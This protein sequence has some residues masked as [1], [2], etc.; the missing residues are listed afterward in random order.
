MKSILSVV[1]ALA[2]S[3]LCLTAEQ[4][5]NYPAEEP[6]FSIDFPDDWKVKAEESVSASSPDELVHMELIALEAEAKEEAMDLA[7]ESLAEELKGIKWEG[8]PVSAEA[9]GMDVT[10]LNGKVT[11][12]EVE[13]AVSCVI[14]APK[15]KDTFFM[16]FNVI[17]TVALEKHGES[18]GKILGSVKAK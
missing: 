17:P 7:K 18:V 10:F 1:T 8:K 9:N 5:I 2:V 6:I 11:L 12:E 15:G 3:S 4:T 13:M 14:F 16:L